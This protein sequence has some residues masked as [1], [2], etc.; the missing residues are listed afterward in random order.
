M[1]DEE[2]RRR[3][4]A[5]EERWIDESGNS[6]DVPANATGNGL[7][8][9]AGGGGTGGGGTSG[10][11]LGGYED[12]LVGLMWGFFW[13]VYVVWIFREEVMSQRKYIAVAVGVMAN[14]FFGVLRVSA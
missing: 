7:G 6:G 13:P 8:G 1:L 3:A 2:S 9:T 14:L 4:L 5:L 10:S 12:F 11:G